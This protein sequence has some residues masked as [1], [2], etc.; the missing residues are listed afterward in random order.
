MP[1]PPTTPN[2]PPPLITHRD[3][4]RWLGV[5]ERQLD[6]LKAAGE[7]PYLRIGGR[8]I[9]YRPESLATW[10]AAQERVENPANDR[11]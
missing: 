7:I 2:A 4:A 5:S 8:S 9:R 6:R 10:A 1:D 11:R 3:A